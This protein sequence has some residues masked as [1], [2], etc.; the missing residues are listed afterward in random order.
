MMR[1]VVR[2]FEEADPEIRCSAHQLS[3]N[4]AMSHVAQGLTTLGYRVEIGKKKAEKIHVPVLCTIESAKQL[5][6]GY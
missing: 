4:E 2:V 1:S 6:S 5:L 3:S